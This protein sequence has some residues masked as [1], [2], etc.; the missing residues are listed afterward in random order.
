[1]KPALT[2]IMPAYNEEIALS[3]VLPRV[4]N[5]CR[6]RSWKLIV[7]NDGSTDKTGGI[8]RQYEGDPSLE[9]IH[10]KVNRGY[11]AAL[12]TGILAVKSPYLVTIDADG[13]HRLEDIDQLQRELLQ[14]NADMI[15]GSRV[16]HGSASLYRGLGKSIIRAIARVL[17][18]NKISDLNSGMKLYSTELAKRYIVL[19]PDSMAFSDIITLVFISERN[20]VIE[21]PITVN[22]RMAGCSTIDT[23][24]AMNTVI[25]VFNMLMLFNP[26]RVLVPLSLLTCLAGTVWGV[27]FI[28]R[29]RG[30]SV[31]ALL[32]LLS[33]VILFTFGLIAQQ[34]SLIRRE[35]LAFSRNNYD[36]TDDGDKYSQASVKL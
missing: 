19:C 34:L 9:I 4:L 23:R 21:Y 25:E 6:E 27:Q 1:M 15:I 16:N 31:A 30:L 29:G 13:Q 8:L 2:V 20:L 10:H 28:L 5:Y 7:V 33:G 11:G 12:K 26:L 36:T 22:Q 32:L 17:V 35:R 14:H 3:S 18:P 24:T